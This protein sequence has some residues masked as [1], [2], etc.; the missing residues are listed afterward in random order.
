MAH[1]PESV[2]REELDKAQDLVAVGE[3]YAH[4]KQPEHAYTV[5]TIGITEEDEQPAVVYQAEYGERVTFIRPLSSWLE[6][7]DDNGTEKPRFAPLR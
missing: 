4:Y 3:R 7:V 2:L 6:T 1:T 5:L